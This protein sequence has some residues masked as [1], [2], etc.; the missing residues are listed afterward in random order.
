MRAGRGIA[1]LVQR[2]PRL[3]FERER[4]TSMSA[5]GASRMAEDGG[6][7]RGVRR[8]DVC[9]AAVVVWRCAPGVVSLSGAVSRAFWVLVLRSLG[10]GVCGRGRRGCRSR[11]HRGAH[12][13]LSRLRVDGRHALDLDPVARSWLGVP[14]SRSPLRSGISHLTLAGRWGIDSRSRCVTPHSGPPCS[15]L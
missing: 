10:R 12:P 7:G 11:P 15:T 5:S 3:W 2:P 8:R 9:R 1:Q 14:G 4:P 6:E 13:L